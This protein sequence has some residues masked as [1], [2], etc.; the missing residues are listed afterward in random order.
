MA[1]TEVKDYLEN[2]NIVNSVNLPCLSKDKTGGT[3]VCVIAKVDADTDAIVKATGS[4]DF[5]TA[6]RGDF[7]YTII[8]NATYTDVNVDGVIKVRS[9]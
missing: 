6:T 9:L 2:G 7:S 3:R 5:A 4:D 8:D 1:A